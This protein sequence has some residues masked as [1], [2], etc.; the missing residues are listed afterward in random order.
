[1]N[2]E[3]FLPAETIKKLGEIAGAHGG[4]HTVD[5]E[6]REYEDGKLVHADKATLPVI[7]TVDGVRL[8]RPTRT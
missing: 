5:V 1:M 2:D 3:I 6:F 8:G 4:E 7:G